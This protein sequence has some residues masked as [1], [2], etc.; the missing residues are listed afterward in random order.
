MSQGVL[1]P[2]QM[3]LDTTT[4]WA[5]RDPSKTK[6]TGCRAKYLI[7]WQNPTCWCFSLSSWTL[8]WFSSPHPGTPV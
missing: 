8:S 4:A 2:P 6:R 7:C 3:S 1:L 5:E